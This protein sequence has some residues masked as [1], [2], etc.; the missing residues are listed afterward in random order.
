MKYFTR[1]FFAIAALIAMAMP[2]AADFNT[3]S[4]HVHIYTGTKNS[5][6]CFKLIE[7][8][9]S[10]GVIWRLR[11]R[12]GYAYDSTG[13]Y[14]CPRRKPISRATLLRVIRE[15]RASWEACHR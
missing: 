12:Y 6:S 11:K 13:H 14:F 15:A 1:A 7:E 3:G 4:R 8:P 9:A 5:G 2:A 10:F